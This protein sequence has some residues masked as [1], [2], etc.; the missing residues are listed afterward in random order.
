MNTEELKREILQEAHQSPF[1]IHPRSV[2][3]YKD[4]KSLYWWPGMKSTITNFVSRCLNCQRIKAEHLAP[5]GLLHPIE[6][7]QWKWDRITMNFSIDHPNTPR[8]HDFVWVIV[9]RFT[10]SAHFIH[11]QTT[12][13]SDVLAKTYIN[14]VIR[15]H[16]IPMSIIFDQDPKFTSRF[17]KSLQKALGT[18]VHLNI[19]F[20]LQSDGQSERV[21]Q[22]LEDMLR[23]CVIDFEKNWEKSLPLAVFTYNNSYQASI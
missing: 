11:V 1:S 4:L 12:M 7:P 13:S 6:F 8:K 23:E 14:E 21:I 2:K 15:L 16:E 10:K 20:H 22:V 5:T 17:W 3:M 9:D 18:K 19:A